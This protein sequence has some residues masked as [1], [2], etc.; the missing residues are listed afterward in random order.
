VDASAIVVGATSGH[1]V[2]TWVEGT[3]SE[4]LTRHQHRPVLAVPVKVVDWKAAPA[5]S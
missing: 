2:R 3:V 5:T 4:R 1:R